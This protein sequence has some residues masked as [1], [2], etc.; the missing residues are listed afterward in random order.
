[1]FRHEAAVKHTLLESER[2]CKKT[3]VQKILRTFGSLT[4]KQIPNK[5]AGLFQTGYLALFTDYSKS[6]E[7]EPDLG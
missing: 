7:I 6:T 3:N 4:S 1:M 2:P 5:P